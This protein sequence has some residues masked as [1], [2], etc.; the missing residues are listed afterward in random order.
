LFTPHHAGSFGPNRADASAPPAGD[1][2]LLSDKLVYRRA[3]GKGAD[4]PFRLKGILAKY[5]SHAEIFWSEL[6]AR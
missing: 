1:A 4:A 3:S 6:E 2:D 5:G